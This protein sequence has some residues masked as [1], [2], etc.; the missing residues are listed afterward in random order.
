M[1]YSAAFP[2]LTRLRGLAPRHLRAVILSFFVHAQNR[3]QTALCMGLKGIK[4]IK[5]IARVCALLCFA[6][7]RT[8]RV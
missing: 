3:P 4:C 7:K 1:A 2:T 6:L 8:I 5:K